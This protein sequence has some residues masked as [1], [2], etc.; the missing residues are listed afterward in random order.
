MLNRILQA[1]FCVLLCFFS[2]ATNAAPNVVGTFSGTLTGLRDQCITTGSPSSNNV[3]ITVTSQNGGT[4]SGTFTVSGLNSGGNV[5]GSI[6]AAG[7][8]VANFVG[9]NIIAGLGFTGNFDG[10]NLVIPP[11]GLSVEDLSMN[12]FDLGGSLSFSGG[13]IINPEEAPSTSIKDSGTIRTEV[14]GVTAPIQQHLVKTLHGPAK[15][16]DFNKQ[17]FFI[18]GEGGLNAGNLQLGN[19]GVWASYNYRDVENDFSRT[20][21]E[22]THHTGLLGIDYSPNKH[23]IIGVAIAYEDSETDTTFNNGELESDGYTV[24]PYIGILLDDN[25][26]LDASMGFSFIDNEQFRI[27]PITSQRVNSSPETDRFFF[28]A[29]VNGFSY[30]DNWILGGRFGILYAKVET[31]QFTESNGSVVGE[32]RTKLGQIRVGG[33]IAY[34]FGEWEPYLAALYEYDFQFDKVELTAG[35][36]PANDRDDLL[37]SSGFRFFN[38]HGFS[39]NFDYTTRVLREDFEEDSITVNVR[40]DF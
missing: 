4:F 19:I 24:S 16:L 34:N 8:I 5:N 23:L 3:N 2:F 7:G 22:S 28:N 40:Y 20:A 33:D 27:D 10:A 39:A 32:R 1:C 12:C 37:I 26:S 13:Q 35:A 17:G 31:E 38:R 29:N 21:F 6:D 36:Q 30:I 15:G 14:L 18:E 25:W 9:P 11:G